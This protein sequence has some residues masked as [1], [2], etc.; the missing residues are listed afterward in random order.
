MSTQR[1]LRLIAQAARKYARAELKRLIATSVERIRPPPRLPLMTLH[2]ANLYED[3]YVGYL[4][5]SL[6]RIE[7]EIKDE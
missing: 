5:A 1:I 7:K 6:A 2:E 4:K 3:T